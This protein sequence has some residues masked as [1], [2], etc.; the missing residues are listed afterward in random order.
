M[1][2]KHP[3]PSG[4]VTEQFD[5]I[6]E[7]LRGNLTTV[8]LHGATTEQI[9]QAATATGRPWPDEL[10]EFFT[11]VNGFPAEQWVQLLPADELFDLD[12]VVHERQ[13]ELDVWGPLSEDVGLELDPDAQAGDPAG[14]FLPEFIPFAGQDGYL[15]FVDTRPGDLHGCVTR[16]HKVDADD[17]GPTWRSI[18]ALLTD[19]ATS[20]HTSSKFDDSRTPTVIDGRLTWQ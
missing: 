9:E 8:H 1:E 2:P 20:L 17:A 18:S 19:L 15:L 6:A 10:I 13:L 7:W 3:T 5:T 16:F 11:H 12:R 14:T 4:S